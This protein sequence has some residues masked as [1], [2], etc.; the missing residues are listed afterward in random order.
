MKTSLVL[1]T[2]ILAVSAMLPARSQAQED[3]AVAGAVF[4]MT[5]NVDNNEVIAYTRGADGSLVQGQTY[6]TGGRGSGGTIDPLASQGSLTLGSSHGL[7]FA[8]NDGSGDIT[9]FQVHGATLT[10]SAQVPS[11]GG[12]PVA[13]AQHGGLVYVVNAG[14][15]SNVTGF[16]LGPNGT[17]TAIAGS[18][19]YLSE[20]T[21][22]PATVAFSPNGQ[23]LLVTEKSSGKI[24]AFGVATTGLLTPLA[25]NLTAGTGLF[26]LTFAPN[27]TVISTETGPPG[28]NNNQ[29]AVSSYTVASNGVMTP[30]SVSVPTLGNATCWDVVTPNGLYVY[31]SSAGG[32]LSGYTI[33]STGTLTPI[34]STVVATLPAHS[35][36]LDIGVSADGNFLYVVDSGLGEVSSFGINSDGTLTTLGIVG[37]VPATAGVNGLAAY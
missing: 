7:L 5:N 1:L 37:G 12:A 18:T 32:V 29:S 26:S 6:S 21:T 17:M 28:N 30:I 31:S 15:A 13:V 35:F 25:V 9:I 24:D 4:V 2:S 16:K 10:K 34:G 33:G 36:N 14:G 11:E 3:A 8:T 27:G 20:L 19:Q 22:A 23:I